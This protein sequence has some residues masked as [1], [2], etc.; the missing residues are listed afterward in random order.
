MAAD[1]ASQIVTHVGGN[2]AAEPSAKALTPVTALDTAG[3]VAAEGTATATGA[4]VFGVGR[5]D[6][7]GMS[8]L[9]GVLGDGDGAALTAVGLVREEARPRRATGILKSVAN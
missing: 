7:L 1:T 3:V 8:F 6:L 4:A 9:P 2:A 5:P